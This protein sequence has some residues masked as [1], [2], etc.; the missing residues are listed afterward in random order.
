MRLGRR[1][2]GFVLGLAAAVVATSCTAPP[3]APTAH[4]RILTG[5]AA[6][7]SA[8]PGG[9]A[10]VAVRPRSSAAWVAGKYG[11]GGLVV[12]AA[13][14]GLVHL[15]GYPGSSSV[16]HSWQEQTDDGGQRWAT[17]RAVRGSD[18]ASAQ[19]AMAFVTARQGWAFT[20]GLFYTTDAGHSWRREA[21]APAVVDSLA[22]A[23]RSTWLV[24]QQCRTGTCPSM[25]YRTDRVGGRLVRLPA[26][27]TAQDSVTSLVRLSPSAAVVIVSTSG[28]RWHLAATDDAAASWTS[29]PDPCPTPH[30]ALSGGGHSS[31]WLACS[32]PSRSMCGC[33]GPTIIYRSR[34]LGATW[35]RMTPRGATA[36]R[37]L[38]TLTA[39]SADIAWAV[40]TTNGQAVVWHTNDAGR[41]WQTTLTGTDAHPLRAISVT[42]TAPGSAWVLG[43]DGGYSHNPI[44]I[45][46]TRDHG[47][48]WQATV[49]P[50]PSGL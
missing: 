50:A 7:S 27:P 17:G 43:V 11:S 20:P 5:R 2:A 16:V 30:A 40:T 46:H 47:H 18:Q 41:S 38:I 45:W 12:S 22:V 48:T 21:A 32:L 13:G 24:G 15:G 49:L 26:Q 6:S 29:Q 23:G 1:Y 31:L 37:G 19:A 42:A 34:D 25:L 36:L 10:S 4:P 8:G 28:H 35:T 33:D 44:S 9:A 3:T 14:T 39:A